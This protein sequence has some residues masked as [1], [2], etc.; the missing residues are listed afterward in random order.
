MRRALGVLAAAAALVLILALAPQARAG[1]AGAPVCS[2]QAAGTSTVKGLSAGVHPVVLVHGW[3]GDPLTDTAALLGPKLG[4]AWQIFQFGYHD[5]S[6]QWAAVPPIA[7]CLAAY[8][9]DLSA[10]HRAVH[11]DGMVYLVGHSMGG[12][13]ARF[14]ADPAWGG[15]PVVDTLGRRHSIA[16]L[17]GGVVTLDT[18]HGGSPWGNT[19]YGRALEA[20][21]FFNPWAAGKQDASRCL[22]LHQ[23]AV[24]MLDGCDVPPYLAP[25][26]PITQVAGVL[27]V[28]RTLFGHH[29]YDISMGGDTI[30]PLDSEAGYIGSGVQGKKATLGAHIHLESV[31]CTVTSDQLLGLAASLAAAVEN[32]ALGLALARL[33]SDSAAMDALSSGRADLAL[34]QFLA[35]ADKFGDCA[36]SN[37]THNESAIAVTATAL[38]ADADAASQPSEPGGTSTAV[39][40]INPLTPGGGLRA[41]WTIADD[42]ASTEPVNCQYDQGS[43]SAVSPGTHWCGSSADSA[44]ACW[45]SPRYP[46]QILCLFDPFGKVLHARRVVNVAQSTTAPARAEPIGVELFDGT[47]WR[48]RNG[49]SWGGRKDDLR[50]AYSCASG[51]ICDYAKTGKTI[52]LLT[53]YG[54]AAVNTSA[55]PWTVRVGEL[56]DPQ[57]AYPPPKTVKIRR[58]FFIT[59]R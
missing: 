48:L 16:D 33:A 43:P 44:D 21:K 8:V 31:A 11:G 58:A 56:G 35:V 53:R 3:T 12:L 49:G 5:Y 52:V 54:V 25:T 32:P 7:A 51:A 14:A 1:A 22:A 40:N 26:I 9:A 50:G 57:T 38:K 20:K 18:P 39:T 2:G 55:Q 27:T 30:V 10:A 15:T 24:G 37:I 41:G 19:G 34:L 28:N 42:T 23:G 46:G 59:T 47:R 36:H 6:N 4:G 17:V 29:L 13:A 45:T